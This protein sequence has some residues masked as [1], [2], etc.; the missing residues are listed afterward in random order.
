MRGALK[1]PHNPEHTRWQELLCVCVSWNSHF[2]SLHWE[3]KKASVWHHSCYTLTEP[4]RPTGGFRLVCPTSLFPPTHTNIHTDII[5]CQ[6]WPQHINRLCVQMVFEDLYIYTQHFK[7]N[8]N[9]AYSCW[10]CHK[11]RRSRRPTFKRK[12]CK[13]WVTAK[14]GAEES[15]VPG[16][17]STLLQMDECWKTS[18]DCL[19]TLVFW[20]IAWE[21]G[22]GKDKMQFKKLSKSQ[23]RFYYHL[24]W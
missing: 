16:C 24:R 5:W 6:P 15:T 2:P 14:N 7:K 4:A 22:G 19:V 8:K 13:L 12:G 23:K 3:R 18:W 1:T 20:S 21:K 11:G 17:V 9:F 10:V